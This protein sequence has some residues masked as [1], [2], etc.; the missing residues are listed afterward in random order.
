MDV[1]L[2]GRLCVTGFLKNNHLAKFA[3]YFEKYWAFYFRSLGKN[4]ARR[5]RTLVF[6]D[7]VI[8]SWSLL[9]IINRLLTLLKW[10]QNHIEI[11]PCKHLLVQSQQQKHWEKLW[12]MFKVKDKTLERRHWCLAGVFIV[13]FEYISQL[14]LLFLLLTLNK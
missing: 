14:F 10:R 13:N 5:S 9:I 8:C 2:E 6:E 1:R 12:N 3:R 11:L 4:I 7:F